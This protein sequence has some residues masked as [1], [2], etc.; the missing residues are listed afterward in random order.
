M[1]AIKHLVDE[2][3]KGADSDD[4]RKKLEENFSEFYNS[5]KDTVLSIPFDE[6]FLL[7]ELKLS[8][9]L[10]EQEHRAKSECQAKIVPLKM[11]TSTGNPRQSVFEQLPGGVP[12]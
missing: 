6:K 10:L 1:E 11:V 8:P 7:K 3:R 4:L 12:V 9:E 2:I 5:K